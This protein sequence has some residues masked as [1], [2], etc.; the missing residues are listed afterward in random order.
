MKNSL[1]SMLGVLGELAAESCEGMRPDVCRNA[2]QLASVLWTTPDSFF[3]YESLEIT[4]LDDGT[5]PKPVTAQELACP[6]SQ[7]LVQCAST[8]PLQTPGYVALTAAIEQKAPPEHSGFTQRCVSFACH[9]LL[10]DLTTIVPTDLLTPNAESLYEMQVLDFKPSINLMEERR[11]S[12]NNATMR[13]KLLL[14]YLALLS[15]IGMVKLTDQENTITTFVGLLTFL[16]ALAERLSHYIQI[17]SEA[18]NSNLLSPH[19]ELPANHHLLQIICYWVLSTLPY[20]TAN[21]GS[22]IGTRD[23]NIQQQCSEL[24]QKV[25]VLIEHPSL[26]SMFAPAKGMLALYLSRE[27]YDPLMAGEEQQQDDDDDQDEEED[28][29]NACADTL[30]EL[31]RVCVRLENAGWDISSGVVKNTTTDEDGEEEEVIVACG[32]P[33]FCLLSDA[34]WEGLLPSFTPSSDDMQEINEPFK[35]V[36]LKELSI[37]VL[38]DPDRTGCDF[39]DASGGAA[40]QEE[41]QDFFSVGTTVGVSKGGFKAAPSSSLTAKQYASWLKCLTLSTTISSSPLIV[42]RFPILDEDSQH[43]GI[44]AALKDLTPSDRF[45]LS[46][47]VREVVFAHTPSVAGHGGEYTSVKQVASHILGVVFLFPTF[48]GQVTISEDLNAKSAAFTGSEMFLL[49]ETILG[50]IAQSGGPLTLTINDSI[51]FISRVV[52]ELCKLAPVT[53]PP[54]LALGVGLVIGDMSTVKPAVRRRLSQWFAFHLSNTDFQWPYW[55]HWEKYV[56]S[57]KPHFLLSTSKTRFLMEVFDSCS[58]LFAPQYVLESCI[59]SQSPLGSLVPSDR[60]FTGNGY[61]GIDHQA[62]DTQ[63]NIPLASVIQILCSKIASQDRPDEI[64]D[65][66]CSDVPWTSETNDANVSMPRS[67]VAI[68]ALV[69]HATQTGAMIEEDALNKLVDAASKY[70]TVLAAAMKQDAIEVKSDENIIFVVLEQLYRRLSYNSLYLTTVLQLLIGKYEVIPLLSF[71]TFILKR[72]FEEPEL[73]FGLNTDDWK[74]VFENVRNFADIGIMNSMPPPAEDQMMIDGDEDVTKRM[75]IVQENINSRLLT[76]C[77]CMEH[78]VGLMPSLLRS[79]KNDQGS[80]CGKVSPHIVEIVEGFREFTML[81]HLCIVNLLAA[82]LSSRSSPS[83][84][85]I[86]AIVAIS[87]KQ[88]AASLT[89]DSFAQ[90]RP[91]VQFK[92][93]RDMASGMSIC[94]GVYLA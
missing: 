33:N 32:M 79:L 39:G 55:S 9:S 1:S 89:G 61:A 52:V 70:Q 56:P 36:G 10:A 22:C 3:K 83:E 18:L 12:L 86:G 50:I 63:E 80:M 64:A 40:S 93:I 41:D 71:I 81:V 85:E 46:E 37:L 47:C 21:A 82:G 48:L 35:P 25:R 17:Q 45:F 16:V 44:Q 20:L 2:R 7:L 8:L 31:L 84:K 24:L 54:A 60:S 65:W 72:R 26:S 13:V 34:P 67:H 23:C 66:I 68:N 38:P 59:P 28:D 87:S 27:E 92:M 42:G 88:L 91:L 75:Q 11:Q 43:A 30:Q 5:Q 4:V 53:F 76:L 19:L 57:E 15:K 73:R 78:V 77:E 49:M 6:T 29:P 69:F 90:V 62:I 51:H 14:R 94:S 74:T 58:H